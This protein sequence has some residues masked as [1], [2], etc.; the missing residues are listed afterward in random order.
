MKLDWRCR[1]CEVCD[2]LVRWARQGEP[3]LDRGKAHGADLLCDGSRVV[4]L[5]AE[6]MGALAKQK[7]LLCVGTAFHEACALAALTI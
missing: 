4:T 7:V 3:A 1:G 6:I 2:L 5:G